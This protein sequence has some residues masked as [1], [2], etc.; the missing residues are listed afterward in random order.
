MLSLEN[1]DRR[2]LYKSYAEYSG[3]DRAR[4]EAQ[5]AGSPYLPKYHI[6]PQSGILND[7][8]GFS[9]YNGLWR[10]FYQAFPFGAV[11]GAKSWAAV[12][13]RD[14]VRWEYRGL[15]LLP[16]TPFDSHGVFSGSALAHEDKLLLFY[17]GNVRTENRERRSYQICAAMD[18]NGD[19]KK[20]LPPFIGDLPKGY[21]AHF[22]DPQVFAHDGEYRLL[23]GAQ[24]EAL[25]GKILVYKSR[26]MKD[27]QLSGELRFSGQTM[28]YMI[29]CPNLVFINGRPILIF[30]PQGLEQSVAPYANITGWR[31]QRGDTVRKSKV[32][33][34]RDMVLNIFVDRS[35]FEIFINKGEKSITGRFF[36]QNGKDKIFITAA[37]LHPGI[38]IQGSV[39]GM[40][41]SVRA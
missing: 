31:E 16:D 39:W 32:S 33:T 11:H 21:T 28:G 2:E 24:N 20:Q 4:V 17:T 25:Q 19:I 3:E 7:P 14:L 40:E 9:F 15:A 36:P 23:L 35:V 13:S 37:A 22:R 18:Q 34:R 29:E 30:C 1:Q 41:A 26:D 27:W 38:K 12:V 10:L 8:N 5:T 6:H